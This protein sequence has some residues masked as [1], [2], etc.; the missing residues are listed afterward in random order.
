MK[1]VQSFLRFCGFYRRFVEKYSQLVRP[2][3][4]LTRKNVLFVWDEKCQAA[5]ENVKKKLSSAPFIQH[6]NPE[7]PTSLETDAS[8]G[9]VSGVL[10]QKQ[11]DDL[12]RPVAYY[13]RVM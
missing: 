9:V 13:S 4:R 7:L 5:F 10:T 6:F 2:L 1:A 12:W 8:D 11:R 3:S